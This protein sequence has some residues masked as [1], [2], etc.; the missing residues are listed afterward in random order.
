[1][2]YMFHCPSLVHSAVPLSEF[3]HLDLNL[4]KAEGVSSLEI[5]QSYCEA[6]Q[7]GQ[8]MIPQLHMHSPLAFPS[9]SPQLDFPAEGP[10]GSRPLLM[11]CLL[12]PS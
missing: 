3:N 8:E 9:I 12:D 1:M 10:M 5:I 4:L 7:A 11:S 2:K 6:L